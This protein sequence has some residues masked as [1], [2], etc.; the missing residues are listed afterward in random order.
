MVSAVHIAVNNKCHVT[1]IIHTHNIDIVLSVLLPVIQAAVLTEAE[2]ADRLVGTAVVAPEIAVYHKRDNITCRI[3]HILGI[4]AGHT[5]VDAGFRQNTKLRIKDLL[6]AP[7]EVQQNNV[8]VGLSHPVELT[9]GIILRLSVLI[10]R[11]DHVLL[12]DAGRRL[13]RFLDLLHWLLYDRRCEASPGNL[14]E[15]GMNVDIEER[16]I[17]PRLIRLKLRN[18]RF[19]LRFIQA[20]LRKHLRVGQ[21]IADLHAVALY[22][23]GVIPGRLAVPVGNLELQRIF[24]IH[25]NRSF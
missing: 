15:A 1:R 19:R 3:R 12:C 10:L 18:E 22:N 8:S 20:C 7:L 6:C 21:I 9:Y 13:I 24:L 11:T 14:V 23:A 16:R 5:E 17:I 4:L 2:H 25:Q